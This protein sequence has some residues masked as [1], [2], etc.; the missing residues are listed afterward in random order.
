MEADVWKLVLTSL[1]RPDSASD[2]RT[3]WIYDPS[4]VQNIDIDLRRNMSA[5]VA[6]DGRSEGMVYSLQ[7]PDEL[8]AADRNGLAVYAAF[9][10]RLKLD[11]PHRFVVSD[12]G[13]TQEIAA[14][15]STPCQPLVDRLP[16][17]L[18]E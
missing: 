4:D 5:F 7:S 10:Q 15:A 14:A 3:Y 2:Y 6:H 16:V 12:W 18:G 8:D 11:D 1:L 17:V 9:P 13:M